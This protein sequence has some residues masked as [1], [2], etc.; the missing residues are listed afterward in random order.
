MLTK[1]NI[2]VLQYYQAV[3]LSDHWTQI[4]E[5][6]VPVTHPVSHTLTVRSFQCCPWNEVREYLRAV[7]WKMMDI[8]DSVNDMWS[9]ITYV[10]HE[11][12]LQQLVLM[13]FLPGFLWKLLNS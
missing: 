10:L 2:T 4:F 8:Y 3:G 5:E 12:L 11:C 7:P 1:P 9:F 6:D 13:A